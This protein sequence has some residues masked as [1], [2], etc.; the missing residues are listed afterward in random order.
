MATSHPFLCTLAPFIKLNLGLIK[1]LIKR[2]YPAKDLTFNKAKLT[3]L[4]NILH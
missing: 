1:S 3:R 2:D 4:Q